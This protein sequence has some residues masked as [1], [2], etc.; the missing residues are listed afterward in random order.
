MRLLHSMRV[1]ITG[2]DVGIRPFIIGLLDSG[3]CDI[4]STVMV[5]TLA[6]GAHLHCLGDRLVKLDISIRIGGLRH[7]QLETRVRHFII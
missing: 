2:V 6:L 7:S 3:L 1:N 4:F 5:C